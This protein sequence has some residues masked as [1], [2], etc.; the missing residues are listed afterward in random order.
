MFTEAFQLH[1]KHTE[2][3]LKKAIQQLYTNNH[4]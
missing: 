1:F 4:T 3:F 2:V